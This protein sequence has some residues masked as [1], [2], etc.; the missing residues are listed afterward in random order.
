MV[1]G[2][3]RNE[4]AR[5]DVR[6]PGHVS[7]D[8]RAVVIVSRPRRCHRLVGVGHGEGGGRNRRTRR[9]RRRKRWTPRRSKQR[10]W[11]ARLLREASP[12]EGSARRAKLAACGI[13]G[14]GGGWWPRHR[15]RIFTVLLPQALL[16]CH[17][18][19]FCPL[20]TTAPVGQRGRRPCPE[21]ALDAGAHSSAQDSEALGSVGA[22]GAA[23]SVA[24]GAVRAKHGDGFMVARA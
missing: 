15:P 13:R 22:P 12:F 2:A 19:Q 18:F 1:F 8:Q 10:E 17:R 9:V 5:D 4:L 3:S 6:V 23:P 11:P 7:V 20:T 14:S 16:A 24:S 21:Q